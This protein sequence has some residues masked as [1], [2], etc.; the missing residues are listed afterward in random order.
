MIELTKRGMS[1]QVAHEVIRTA[2]MDALADNKP[3]YEIL[4]ENKEVTALVSKDEIEKL[5]D[6]RAYIGTAVEQVERVVLKLRKM[7]K[8]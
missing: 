2:S 8:E 5:L 1:R 4:S 6:P 3:L 7:K